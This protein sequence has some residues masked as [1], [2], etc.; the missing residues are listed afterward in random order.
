MSFMAPLM[1]RQTV[2]LRFLLAAATVLAAIATIGYV[3]Y[4]YQFTIRAAA[5]HV[6]HGDSVS[7]AGYRVAVPSR[8]FV[9]DASDD[10]ASLRN[11]RT[12]EVVWL[13][14]F[15]KSSNFSLWFWSYLG[16]RRMNRRETPILQRRELNVA[17]ETF[18]C[19]ER[20][21]GA[22]LDSKGLYDLPVADAECTSA[23]PLEVLFLGGRTDGPPDYSEFY[24]LMASIQKVSQ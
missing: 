10:D 14:S 1:Q 12:E 22:N 5:W 17:G 3:T 23:G 4:R 6:R 2:A 11:A 19:F 7:V 16:Q 9:E 20:D 15:P 24:S 13:R 8:W 18:V 21:F